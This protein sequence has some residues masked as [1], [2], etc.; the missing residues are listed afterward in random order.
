MPEAVAEGVKIN[1]SLLRLIQ[2]DITELELDAFVFYAEPSL[3]LG[4]GFGT[5]ISARGGPTIQK[6]LEGQG[7]VETGGVVVSGAGKLNAEYI[8][9]AVGPRFQEEDTEGKL[10][11]TVRNSLQAADEKG[12]KRIALPAMG[13]GFYGIP[14]DVCARVM[15]DSIKGYLEGETEIQEVVIC[16]ID[17]RE[18]KPFEAVMASL[19]H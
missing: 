13:T 7:P 5:A 18:L 17:Q 1:D 11:T 9:H 19:S 16:V 6:E 14:L 4:S 12:I 8:V 3:T 10:R 15:I 2:G